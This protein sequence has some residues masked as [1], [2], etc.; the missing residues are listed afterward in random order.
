[1]IVDTSAI[2]AILFDEPDA[3][4]FIEAIAAAAESRISAVTFLEATTVIEG[5]RSGAAPMPIER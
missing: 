2:C 1:V 4:R 5:R 3:R